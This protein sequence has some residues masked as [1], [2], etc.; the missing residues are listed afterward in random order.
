M[1]FFNVHGLPLVALTHLEEYCPAMLETCSNCGA[2]FMPQPGSSVCPQCHEAEEAGEDW[3]GIDDGWELVD[4]GDGKKR[5]RRTRAKGKKKARASASVQPVS[6]QKQKH[7]PKKQK[8]PHQP[9][10]DKKPTKS[11]PA[12]LLPVLVFVIAVG[13][14]ILGAVASKS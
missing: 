13:A 3:D 4:L 9:N 10:V 8:P 1:R 6:L 7:K 5:R 14:L 2:Q 12:W 11:R